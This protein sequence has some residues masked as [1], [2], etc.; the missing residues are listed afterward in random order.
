[1]SHGLFDLG[2]TRLKCA[3][4]TA[5]GKPGPVAALGHDAAG[6]IDALRAHLPAHGESA[7]LAS[8][9]SPALTAAVVQVLSE[10]F[11]RISLVR[12]Q[13]AFAGVRV[14]YAAPAKLGVDRFLA[15]VA[16]HARGRGPCLIAGVGTA[17]TLDLLDADGRHHGGRIAPS[18]QLMREALHRAAAQLPATGGDYVEFASDTEDALTSGCEG[19]A[20][21][22]IERSLRSATQTLGARPRLLIHG[23]GADALLHALPDAEISPTLVLEGVA[24]WARAGIG[25]GAGLDR[26]AGC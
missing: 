21:A 20:I 17:L 24:A 3:P 14:A 9:A 11:R 25:E 2:N 1:M 26:I 23:G 7:C 12:T 22:L 18:P 19:A 15:L 8:V 16:A 4:L 5:D 6:F 13:A 10:R